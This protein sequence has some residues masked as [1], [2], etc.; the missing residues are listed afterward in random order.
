MT[1]TLHQTE[2]RTHGIMKNNCN[3]LVAVHI[4]MNLAARTI[5]DARIILKWILK[6][7]GGRN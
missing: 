1:C 7:W 2:Y 4:R 5:I 3:N 6:K